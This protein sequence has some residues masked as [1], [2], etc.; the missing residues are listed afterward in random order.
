MKVGIAEILPYPI[1]LGTD[2][3]MLSELLQD[4]EWCGVVTRAQS[5]QAVQTTLDPDA[6]NALQIL[7]FCSAD[8]EIESD[9][10]EDN[11]LH[12]RRTWVADMIDRQNRLRR[13]L[14][15]QSCVNQTL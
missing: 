5:R 1:L 10:T 9:P 8:I 3:P 7:P 4:I 12:Q 13:R 14:L 11:R 2:M 6:D 15:N